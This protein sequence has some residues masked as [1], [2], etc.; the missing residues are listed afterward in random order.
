MA[1]RARSA[2]LTPGVGSVSVAP[3][4]SVP[5]GCESEQLDV[6]LGQPPA[7][8]GSAVLSDM[9]SG[10][11]IFSA[12]TSAQGAVCHLLDEQREGRVVAFK[13]WYCFLGFGVPQVTDASFSVVSGSSSPP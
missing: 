6:A 11:R 7:R 1:K 4:R 13:Y 3:Q 10:V 9:P 8:V 5:G 12:T 2:R